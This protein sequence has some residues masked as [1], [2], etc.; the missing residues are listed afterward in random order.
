MSDES[1]AKALGAW[2]SA[3][4][5]LRSAYTERATEPKRRAPPRSP[6]KAVL[7]LPALKFA[8]RG[9]SW[10]MAAS[11]GFQET[12]P[13]ERLPAPSVVPYQK[14]QNEKEDK[15]ALR[16]VPGVSGLMMASISQKIGTGFGKL[17]IVVQST[18]VHDQTAE[19]ALYES[20]SD[21][22]K[23]V[24][25]M[26][27]ELGKAYAAPAIINSLGPKMAPVHLLKGVA[28]ADVT[29]LSMNWEMP[30]W[31]KEEKPKRR[32]WHFSP[33]A[34]SAP[35]SKAQPA[36]ATPEKAVVA[37]PRPTKLPPRL[38]VV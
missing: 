19:V 28:F 16:L 21:A 20:E 24:I 37:M 23:A 2:D 34:K 8:D 3:G 27:Q 5:A 32:P 33:I 11:L 31:E 29:D 13:S 4:D 17:F 7:T 6:P 9:E 14:L 18:A 1:R 25:R 10:P 35:K 15:P 30:P 36:K 12:L 26:G 38:V 22:Y